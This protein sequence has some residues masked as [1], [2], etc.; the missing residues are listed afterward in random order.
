ME[1]DIVSFLTGF[2]IN[3]DKIIL[4]EKPIFYWNVYKN[5]VDEFNKYRTIEMYVKSYR[6]FG[7]HFCDEYVKNINNS[8]GIIVYNKFEYQEKFDSNDLIPIIRYTFVPPYKFS[9]I[10]RNICSE[11]ID[12]IEYNRNR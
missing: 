9:Y 6:I 12:I 5:C 11:N 2:G 1:K 10:E 7:K 8:N 4:V 3:S